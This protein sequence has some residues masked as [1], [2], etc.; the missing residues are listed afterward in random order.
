MGETLGKLVG[1][2]PGLT[3]MGD[4]FIVGVAAGMESHAIGNG[5]LANW[6]LSIQSKT[7]DL[8][9]RA[10]FYA[11]CGWFTEPLIDFVHSIFSIKTKLDPTKLLSIGDTSGTAMAYGC[12]L[13]IHAGTNLTLQ[14]QYKT[15]VNKNGP[16][17]LKQCFEIK[18]I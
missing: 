16:Y 5:L 9:G 2:G 15:R 8:S 12:L 7:T 14:K 3:P 17:N 10:L 4:D 13:G 6:L 1:K 18:V 11:A